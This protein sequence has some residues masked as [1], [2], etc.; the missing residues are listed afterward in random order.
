MASD[1]TPRLSIAGEGMIIRDTRDRIEA[2]NAG[3]AGS[4]FDDVNLKD[5]RFENVNLSGAV[6]NNINMSGVKLTNLDIHGMMI[7]GIL[8]EDLFAAFE[9]R[10]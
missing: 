10:K 1:G 3:L 9:A 6:F 4:V 2:Q 7:E 8:V 5:A